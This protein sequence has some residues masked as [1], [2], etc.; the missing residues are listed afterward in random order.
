[1]PPSHH[2]HSTHGSRTHPPARYMDVQMMH[3]SHLFNSNNN[4]MPPSKQAV[5]ATT[6]GATS[7]NPDNEYTSGE[8]EQGDEDDTVELR[9]PSEAGRRGYNEDDGEE[10]EDEEADETEMAE[11]DGAELDFTGDE[12]DE[13]MAG[14]EVNYRRKHEQEMVEEEASDQEDIEGEEDA[15]SISS[16]ASSEEENSDDP[17][18]IDPAISEEMERFAH[19]FKGFEKRYRL[20]NKI[21]EGT[22]SSVYKAEDLLYDHYDNSWDIDYK[23]EARWAAPPS[24]KRRTG[25]GNHDIGPVRPKYVAIKKIYVT[26]SP[27]R[28]QNELELLHD[29]SGCDSVVPLITAFRYQDQVVAVLP[30]FKHVDFREYFRELTIPHIRSYFKSLFRAL[31][32][33][34]DNG[35]IHRDIKPTN[36]LYDY[37]YGRGVLV[38]FGL[39]ERE[40]TDSQYCMCQHSTTDRKD[41]RPPTLAPSAG[42]PKH[43]TRPSRRA[44]RAG[45]RGFRA[46]EVLF[47]CTNQTTKIDIWSAGVILLTILSRR[48]PFFNSSDDVDAMIEIAT[49]FGKQRMKQ[50]AALH[51]CVFES[52]IPTIGERGFTLEKIVLWATNRTATGSSKDNKDDAKLDQ[53]EA[54]AI[55]FLQRCFE[56]DPV[57]RTSAVEALQHEFLASPDWESPEPEH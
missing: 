31:A 7:T 48:F 55:K 2:T 40:G 22:F 37:R 6:E 4:S 9:E 29:L 3:A 36:F 52:T 41:H 39:A 35:I 19:T 28:I 10:V 23:D 43:E 20:V 45:T 27:T 38:D 15:Q 1:M 25:H 30:Y 49:I 26:S 17:D 51:G 24:K 50:C 14:E 21:G 57:K 56:L 33:V 16:N 44:N 8:S 34:H 12:I 42:Y 47:K 54:L 46:P 11:G 32:H 53:D 5:S 18:R 13:D